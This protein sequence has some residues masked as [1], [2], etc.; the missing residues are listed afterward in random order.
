M[1]TKLNWEFM[2]GVIVA[3][4]ISCFMGHIIRT[5]FNNHKD[6]VQEHVICDVIIK[7]VKFVSTGSRYRVIACLYIVDNRSNGG[8]RV[9]TIGVYNGVEIPI[10]GGSVDITYNES[11]GLI[12]VADSVFRE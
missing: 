11:V 12:S 3:I 1:L 10:G 9:L 6:S 2:L 4:L 5:G 8:Y 7:D